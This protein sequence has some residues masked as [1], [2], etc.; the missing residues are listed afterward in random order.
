MLKGKYSSPELNTIPIQQI[1][2]Q[3][4]KYKQIIII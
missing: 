1:K 3:M 4:N 2:W